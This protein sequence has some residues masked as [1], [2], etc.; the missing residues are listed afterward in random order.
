MVTSSNVIYLVLFALS[1]NSEVFTSSIGEKCRKC[2]AGFY[3][4]Q[5][6]ISENE[7]FHDTVCAPCTSGHFMPLDENEE[8]D[9]NTCSVCPAG[10]YKSSP[11]STTSDTQCESCDHVV[12]SESYRVSCNGGKVDNTHLNTSGDGLTL[13]NIGETGSGS[14]EVDL[15]LSEPVSVIDDD[16]VSS[17][18][19]TEGSGGDVT[20]EIPSSVDEIIIP[21]KTGKVDAVP[22]SK[23]VSEIEEDD[24][25]PVSTTTVKKKILQSMASTKPSVET[26]IVL[27][28]TTSTKITTTSTEPSTKITTP[29]PTETTASSTTIISTTT[30]QTPILDLGTGIQLTDDELDEDNDEDKIGNNIEDEEIIPTKHDGN[31]QTS[32]V[33]DQKTAAAMSDDSDQVSIGIVIAVA[34]IAAIVFFVIGFIVSKYCRRRRQEFKM[35]NKLQKTENPHNGSTPVMLDMSTYRHNG[36]YDEIG[37]DANGKCS[38]SNLDEIVPEQAIVAEQAIVPVQAENVY[39]VPEKRKT[40]PDI[41]YI[42]E[43]D[44]E[45]DHKESETLLPQDGK[46]IPVVPP[47]QNG[48]LSTEI[49][50]DDSNETSPM[51]QEIQSEL[52]HNGEISKEHDSVVLQS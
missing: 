4:K 3:V 9:C 19:E 22:V 7:T 21:E 38:S 5:T 14:D 28:T 13:D 35:M 1:I 46:Q 49:S 10:K 15:V 32:Y 31:K 48:R 34:I 29:K 30:A 27:T 44:D 16:L 40:L 8:T 2:K 20:L 37:K 50:A 6:C 25:I 41:K 36:I 45:I 11:C 39:A 17:E 51:L 43:T 26:A 12:D 24:L 52:A 33:A 18:N 47:K 23:N 42:D